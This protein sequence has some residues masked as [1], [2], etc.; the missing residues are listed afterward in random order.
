MENGGDEKFGMR[1]VCRVYICC[2]PYFNVIIYQNLLSL[3]YWDF[4]IVDGRVVARSYFGQAVCPL[5]SFYTSVTFD[6]VE[7]DGCGVFSL[8]VL[9]L[10]ATAM[11]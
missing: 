10:A 1:C 7:C 9:S 6:P 11:G 4:V 3:V 2:V 5:V 8:I